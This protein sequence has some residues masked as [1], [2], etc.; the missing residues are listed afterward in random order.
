M[1][2]I[3]PKLWSWAS[4]IDDVTVDQAIK[5]SKLG[6]IPSHIAL[7]PDAHLG[8]G[9]TIGS[10][11]PTMNSVIPAAVG[12]DIGCGMIASRTNINE[13]R[14]PDNLDKLL[15]RIERVIPSGVGKGHLNVSDS[16][17]DWMNANPRVENSGLGLTD[18]QVSTA[19]AQYGTLGSGN[20]F[21]E[22]CLDQNRDVWVCLHSGSRGIGNQL[23]AWYIDKAKNQFA[24]DVLEDPE[25]AYLMEGSPVFS[26]YIYDMLWAQEYAFGNR[27]EMMNNALRE[28]ADEIGYARDELEAHRIN[29]HHNFTVRE[30][31]VMDDGSEQWV[32]LTRKGAIR[33]QVGDWGIIPGSMGTRS[34]IIEGRGN[35]DSYNSCAHGAGRRM[36]RGAA[37]RQ[38]TAEDITVAMKGKVWLADK[39]QQLVDEIPQSYKDINTV[40]R[41][42][43]DLVEVKFVLHQILNYKGV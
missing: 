19:L 27:N 6:I 34:Y 25:L 8:K 35:P 33:A 17:M 7:M 26:A 12:V 22:I 10:V 23:A 30:K 40:M 15:K 42:Q 3:T 14:L 24:K 39:A 31:H 21:F 5:A 16:A 13:D 38:F 4:E 20:H 36:S 11:I 1:N 32:W 9:A 43:E 2:K 37:R 18:R 28:F 29:C 41:D